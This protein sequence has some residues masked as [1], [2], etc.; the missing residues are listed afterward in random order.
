LVIER[1][2]QGAHDNTTGKIILVFRIRD[3]HSSG[4]EEFYLLG[5]NAM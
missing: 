5:Y 2:T 3:S 1:H 4:Y